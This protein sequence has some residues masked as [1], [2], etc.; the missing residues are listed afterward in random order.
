MCCT[1]ITEFNLKPALA[2]CSPPC[3][4]ATS[5]TLLFKK[6]IWE[7]SMLLPFFCQS[8]PHLK[9]VTSFLHVS[10]IWPLFCRPPWSLVYYY[11]LLLISP[12]PLFNSTIHSS[13]G[14]QSK[15]PETQDWSYIFQKFP[16][17]FKINSKLHNIPK[18][19]WTLLTPPPAHLMML[20]QLGATVTLTTHT[21]HQSCQTPLSATN[22]FSYSSAFTQAIA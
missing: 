20:L 10:W 8:F 11:S 21:K 16:I 18:K 12:I 5:S 4:I 9:S 22:K 17:I 1:L 3:W 14:S 13:H 2:W 6:V 19:V 15:L 7:L